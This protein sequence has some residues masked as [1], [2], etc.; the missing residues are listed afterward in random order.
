MVPPFKKI[1]K[2][3]LLYH[4]FQSK[5]TNT[6]Y[7]FLLHCPDLGLS[8]LTLPVLRSYRTAALIHPDAALL[9]LCIC[10]LQG[11]QVFSSTQTIIIAKHTY[12]QV[13]RVTMKHILRRQRINSKSDTERN[14]AMPLFQ[15]TA[16]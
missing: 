7:C 4:P 14:T 12:N 1:N 11:E 9:L 3:Y 15:C 10:G 6:E 13:E 16:L 8:Y 2:I 5:Y